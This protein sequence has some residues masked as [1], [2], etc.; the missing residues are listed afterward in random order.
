MLESWQ[1]VLLVLSNLILLLPVFYDLYWGRWT[2]S[3]ILF[4]LFLASVLYHACQGDQSLCISTLWEAQS[5]DHIWVMAVIGWLILTFWAYDP[6]I[7]F[8]LFLAILFLAVINI[9]IVTTTFAFAVFL[10]WF[11]ILFGILRVV[12]FGEP[13][14]KHDIFL[15]VVAVLL[16]GS[17]FALHLV[18]GGTDDS[19]Y[20]WAHST[21]HVLAM[22]G[23]FVTILVRDGMFISW[24][25]DS[26]VLWH[27]RPGKEKPKPPSKPGQSSAA[28]SSQFHPSVAGSMRTSSPPMWPL[29]PPHRDFNRP[30]Y[31]A[32]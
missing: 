22:L 8:A 30:V 11:A 1:T 9:V 32:V 29:S 28:S 4:L 3:T 17:G 7:R 27:P 15:I 14:R 26:S 25:I 23:I 31:G 12:A 20:W 18:A 16:L 10:G 6:E 2:E 24:G 13:I 5:S 21:W 19:K